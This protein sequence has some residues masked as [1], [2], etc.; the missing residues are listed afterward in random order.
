MIVGENG[1]GKSTILDALNFVLF[2]KAFRDIKKDLM[3]NSITRKNAEVAITFAIGGTNYKIVRGIKPK[4]FAIY[5]N[6]EL[7]DSEAHSRDQQEMLETTILK[8]NQKSFNQIVILGIANYVPFMRLPAAERRAVIEDLLDIQIFSTMN[9]LLKD[10]I[11]NNGKALFM[12][13]NNMRTIESKI[14]MHKKHL[15]EMERDDDE[16][17]KKICTEILLTDRNIIEATEWT[18]A[19][20]K[21]IKKYVKTLEER[22]PIRDRIA[23]I[24]V[25]VPQIKSDRVSLDEEVQFYTNSDECRLCKQSIDPDFKKQRIQTLKDNW[26][27]KEIEL[28]NL[29]KEYNELK[30]KRDWYNEIEDL[31]VV[32]NKKCNALNVKILA[33][34][35]RIKKLNNDLKDINT[36][37]EMKKDNTG[38]LLIEEQAVIQ[39]TRAKV[40]HE[41]E[42]LSIASKL[43][44][45]GGIKSKIIKKYVP[46]LNKHINNYLQAMDFFVQFELDEE[47]KETIKSRHRD[48]FTY[49]SF[50]QGEKLRIDLALLFT[51]RKISKIRNSTTTNLLIIDEI[52]D[53]SLDESGITD[54]ITIINTFA[55]STNT[56]VISHKLDQMEE[57]DRVIRFEKK[58]NFSRIAA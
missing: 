27:A 49:S 37:K 50:S 21:E 45:D 32:E 41:K 4:I 36:K 51:W 19:K 20:E 31:I 47:F 58:D 14:Q 18:E 12:S 54:F 53:S 52:L 3:I 5:R 43:L 28:M 39:E 40:I 16:R 30:E 6:G 55:E 42:I 9:T 35:D 10:R 1:S 33:G 56:F 24:G 23:E 44:K 17:A 38:E 57:F 2:G 26:L 25:L 13:D 11:S 7:L 46:V 34:K 22:Q 29:E 48:V 15:E 8:F